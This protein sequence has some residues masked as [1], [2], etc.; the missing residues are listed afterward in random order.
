M[1]FRS[2]NARVWLNMKYQFTSLSY[3]KE[4]WSA[5]KGKIAV[6]APTAEG[7]A[8]T[9]ATPI[10]TTYGYEVNL[11]ALQMLIDEARLER[12]AEFDIYELGAGFVLAL[13]AIITICYLNYVV[14]AIIFLIIFSIPVITG[15]N[16]FANGQLADYTWPV[17]AIT[18]S[19]GFSLFMRFVMEFKLKQQIKKQFETYLSPDRKSTRLNSSH[20]SESRM[21]SSA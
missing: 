9:V 17:L 13:I 3:T 18:V 4:D 5:V 2:A 14:A 10:G 11:Q 20:V 7:L 15:F 1:L 21:P 19:W 16:L 8:N 6:I 12:P